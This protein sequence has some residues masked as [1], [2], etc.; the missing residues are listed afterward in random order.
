[1]TDLLKIF[2]ELDKQVRPNKSKSMLREGNP[3]WKGGKQ[4]ICSGRLSTLMP[5]HPYANANG[6]VRNSRLIVEKKLGRFLKSE[7][8]IHHKDGNIMN[9]DPDNLILCTNDSEHQRLYHSD[10]LLYH[11]DKERDANGRFTNLI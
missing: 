1:M 9:E 6:Y 8:V 10:N 4:I 5:E 7:E 3:N 2:N 11:K